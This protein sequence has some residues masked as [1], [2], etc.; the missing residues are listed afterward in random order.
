MHSHAFLAASGRRRKACKAETQQEL[1]DSW[2]FAN[3]LRRKDTVR[4]GEYMAS[5]LAGMAD[6]KSVMRPSEA[7]AWIIHCAWAPTRSCGG[8]PAGM[9]RG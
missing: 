8:G 1:L 3:R 4:Q 5:L 6:L 9:L 7:M 2:N